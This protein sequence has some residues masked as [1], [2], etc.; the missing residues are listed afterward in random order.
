M[1]STEHS[2]V[3]DVPVNA[4]GVKTAIGTRPPCMVMD[5]D[6]LPALAIVTV[7]VSARFLAKFELLDLLV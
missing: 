1:P 3:N 6:V 5:V 2:N 7:S 4:A